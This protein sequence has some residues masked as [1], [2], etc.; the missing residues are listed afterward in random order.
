[1]KKNLVQILLSLSVAIASRADTPLS[2]GS[3]PPGP[4]GPCYDDTLVVLNPPSATGTFTLSGVSGTGM[5]SSIVSYV[6]D[7][8]HEQQHTRYTYSIDMSGM[9]AATNHCIKL[10]VHFGTPHGCSYDVLMFTGSGVPL[11]SATKA[12]HGDITCVFGSGCLSPNQTSVGFAMFSDAQPKT[13]YVTIVD[14]YTDPAGGGTNEARINVTAVVPDVPPNWAYAPTPIPN[15]FYQGILYTNAVPMKTNANGLYDFALQLFDAASNGLPVGPVITQNVQVVNGLFNIPLPFELSSINWG[16]RWLDVSLRPSGGQGPFV[17]IGRQ[18]LTPA[19]QALYAYSAGVVA[20]VSPLQAV[21]SIN[22]VP[23]DL[24]LQGGTG[25]QVTLNGDGKTLVISQTGQPSDRNI[26]TDFSAVQPQEVL[27]KLLA[28]P[29]QNWRF[30]NEVADVRHLG[31]M[32]QDFHAA[33]GL[34]GTD[35]KHIS[36]VDEGGVALAAIQGLNQKLQEKDAEIQQLKQSVAEL[37]QAVSQ[38]EKT[39]SREKGKE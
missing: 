28:L 33:F 20:D 36:T 9:S 34:N 2:I 30:T 13:N 11:T 27:A 29:I 24:I 4:G 8:V 35:D 6:A 37:R 22:G 18:A 19:P 10:I 31:P 23:G 1:M 12:I 16:D 25:I 32:A 7:N 21:T 3:V 17:E 39:N 26:K 5:V 38:L 14:D 15:P